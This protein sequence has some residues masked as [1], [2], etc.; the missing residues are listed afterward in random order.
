VVLRAGTQVTGVELLD[1]VRTHLARYKVPRAVDFVTALP[2]NA[3]GKIQKFE[4]RDK[5]WA[6]HPSRIQG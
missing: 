5:E 1:H 4:I 6:G 2:R 3:N